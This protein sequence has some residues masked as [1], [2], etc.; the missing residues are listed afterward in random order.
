MRYPEAL[1]AGQRAAKNVKV[2]TSKKFQ[3]AQ[4]AGENLR[5]KVSGSVND[6]EDE[7]AIDVIKSTQKQGENLKHQATDV[8]DKV[9]TAAKSEKAHAEGLLHKVYNVLA[10]IK[11]SIITYSRQKTIKDTVIDTVSASAKSGAKLATDAAKTT[12]DYVVDA[13][14]S[15]AK[16]NQA[17]V[18]SAAKG[19]ILEATDILKQKAT[20]AAKVGSEYAEIFGEKVDTAT[21][22]DNSIGSFSCF[23]EYADELLKQSKASKEIAKEKLDEVATEINASAK[24]F[25]ADAVKTTGEHATQASERLHEKVPEA[26]AAGKKFAAKAVKIGHKYGKEALEQT[27]IYAR[28]VYEAGKE[29][30]GE[31]LKDAK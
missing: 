11:D 9:K 4:H 24:E 7:A 21:E 15:A 25:A 20:K 14:V 16:V 12:G 23:T 18:A 8:R 31:L 29:K 28:Q 5:Q 2:A 3:D 10:D 17:V 19:K 27:E 6:L 13:A 30:A 26:I 1:N 22:T